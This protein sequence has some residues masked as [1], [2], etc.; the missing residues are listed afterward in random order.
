MAGI[1]MHLLILSL[2]STMSSFA[3]VDEELKFLRARVLELEQE[4]NSQSNV[5]PVANVDTKMS[6]EL[7][8]AMA[9]Q[10]VLD[11]GTRIE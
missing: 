1:L 11:T 6:E 8:D 5:S 10:L 9:Q 2:R 4:K 7:T 3:S